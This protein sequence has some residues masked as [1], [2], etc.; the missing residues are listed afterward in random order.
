MYFLQRAAEPLRLDFVKH[1]YG[2]YADNLRKVLRVMEGH[3]VSGFGDGSKPVRDSEP[4]SVLPGAMAAA[5]P[6]LDMH[7]ETQARIDRGLA[8]AEGFES[9]FGL[10]LLASVAWIVDEEPS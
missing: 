8:L 3:F 10:D 5:A 6:V 1:L 7:P 2:P 9:A 4:L